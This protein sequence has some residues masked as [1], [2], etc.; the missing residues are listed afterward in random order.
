MTQTRIIGK[1]ATDRDRS[2]VLQ[3]MEVWG[4]AADRVERNMASAPTGD[5]VVKT[6]RGEL[7]YFK[8]RWLM[9]Y[10]RVLT[11]LTLAEVARLPR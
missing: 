6:A 8:E 2:E 4:D 10:H 11:V 3:R 9:S 1:L 5:F 7:K